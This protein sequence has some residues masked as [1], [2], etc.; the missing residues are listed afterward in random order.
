MGVRVT[1]I[2][3]PHPIEYH[4]RNQTI[5]YR[6]GLLLVVLEGT[7][8]LIDRATVGA[9]FSCSSSPCLD[10]LV[11]MHSHKRSGLSTVSRIERQH[12]S[13]A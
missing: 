13:W 10:A 7:S 9:G 2:P 4:A 6:G 5:Q 1:E 8:S 11:L 12:L 3:P